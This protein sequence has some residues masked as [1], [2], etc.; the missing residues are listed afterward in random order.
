M[1]ES[2]FTILRVRGIPI[3]VHW[4]WLLVFAIVVWSLGTALF[5]ATYPGLDGA[6]Y[7]G[8]AVAAA[9]LFFGSVLAHELGHALR[10]LDEGQHIEGI[11]LWLFGGVARLRGTPPSPGTELRVAAAG[12]A[13]SA[14][15]A[16][17]FGGAALAG[18]RLGWPAALQGVVDYLGRINLILLAFNLVPA[19]EHVAGSPWLPL[20]VEQWARAWAESLEEL[21]G[22]TTN[23]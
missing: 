18:D 21:S 11:T 22:D 12:P 10:A 15:L 8:M 5:P 19:L 23:P 3:G 6:T 2:S 20:H 1:T 13:I 4:T 7:L 14:L 16:A 17:L 9:L